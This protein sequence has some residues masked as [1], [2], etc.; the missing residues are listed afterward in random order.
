MSEVQTIFQYLAIASMGITFAGLLLRYILKSK[1][2][3]IS[4]CCGFIECDRNVVLE[5]QLDE[6]KVRHGLS[7]NDS[8]EELP[9]TVHI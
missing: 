3:H 8:D 6:L 5:E 7:K 2:S 9:I 1:C 4:L